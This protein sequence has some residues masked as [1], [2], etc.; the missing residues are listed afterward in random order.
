MINQQQSPDEG[1]VQRLE[2]KLVPL[3][4]ET[5][6]ILTSNVEDED[7]VQILCS[8]RKPRPPKT[9]EVFLKK[10]FE[11]YG[12]KYDYDLSNYTGLTSNKIRIFCPIHGW[13]EQIPHTFLLI[14]CKTGCK[15]CGERMKNYSKTKNYENFLEKAKIIHRHKYIYSELNRP[16]YINRKSKIKITCKEHGEFIKSAQKH[17]SGQGCYKCN[18]ERMTKNNILIGGY[19]EV[20]FLRRPELKDREA[21]LYYININEGEYYKIGISTSKKRFIGIKCNA[22]S[23]VRKIELIWKV[24]DSLYN[25]FKQ[26][27]KILEFY[28]EKRVFTSWSNELFKENILPIKLEN[29]I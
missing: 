28:K 16:L 22:K 17:L 15:K 19:C 23:I 8:R 27:Q 29:I 7:I 26:E 14:N 24:Y 18:V 21:Y 3:N 20:L 6:N 11:K 9:K 13:F 1:N 12:N 10:A 4:G 5:E 2:Q 25:C